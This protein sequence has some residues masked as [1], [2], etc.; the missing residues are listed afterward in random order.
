MNFWEWLTEYR[1]SP[2]E[3]ELA[4]RVNYLEAE[5]HREQERYRELVERVAF[6]QS[7]NHND[8]PQG[9]FQSVPTMNKAQA[10]AHRLSQLS[11]QRLLDQIAEMERRA[12]SIS[13]RDEKLSREANAQTEEQK[14]Q[15][16]F[17]KDSLSKDAP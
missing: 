3:Q 16:Q 2:L 13:S 14:G 4:R 11:K 12:A 5:L 6:P 8:V 9:P 10:E 7:N 15:G 1:Y 17:L